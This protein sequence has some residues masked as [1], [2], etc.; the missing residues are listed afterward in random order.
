MID[1]AWKL[2]TNSKYT[3]AGEGID[4][5]TH[6]F[7]YKDG[8][9]HPFIIG[10]EKWRS[11]KPGQGAVKPGVILCGRD[12]DS[13]PRQ[14]WQVDGSFMVF[15]YLRQKVPEFDK[16]CADTASK[17]KLSKDLIGA[18]MVGRWKSGKYH[19]FWSTCH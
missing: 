18:R 8:I 16:F 14:A 3:A 1:P 9:S 7:G 10:T 17:T 12:G 19:R 5:I 6:S 11:E 15:R 4:L 13:I 2:A